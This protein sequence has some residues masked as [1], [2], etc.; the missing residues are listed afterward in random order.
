MAVVGVVMEF[1]LRSKRRS[2][3][4]VPSLTRGHFS[5]IDVYMYVRVYVFFCSWDQQCASFEKL[6]S[7][8][9]VSLG[10]LSMYV[11][12]VSLIFPRELALRIRRS[13]SK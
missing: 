2:L 11:L 5:S 12:L 8:L 3:I 4:S 7:S 10:R 6:L 1:K 13:F 9:S